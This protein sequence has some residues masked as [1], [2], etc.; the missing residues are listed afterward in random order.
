MDSRRNFHYEYRELVGEGN[1]L[2]ASEFNRIAKQ[3]IEVPEGT[4][5]AV[6]GEDGGNAF[7][8]AN[9]TTMLTNPVTGKTLGISFDGYV[10][11]NMLSGKYYVLNDKDY[12]KISEGLTDE[13]RER[14]VAFNVADVD[15]SYGFAQE[16]YRQI[17]AS[18][19]SDCQVT[20]WTTGFMTGRPVRAVLGN[21]KTAALT[22]R[23]ALRNIS[24]FILSSSG[25]MRLC[26]VYWIKR[27][28]C[29][30]MPYF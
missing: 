25:N 11:D 29:P 6:I 8:L 17:V 30:P 24:P 20:E 1:Y 4:C 16:L 12:M 23:L 10:C 21:M 27:T 19:G 18:T 5:R 9:D 7:W 13:W 28:S 3:D 26:S 15:G 14:L 2:P 22:L